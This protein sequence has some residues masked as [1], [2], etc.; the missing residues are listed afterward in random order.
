MDSKLAKYNKAGCGMKRR[1]KGK[2]K[3]TN[4]FKNQKKILDMLEGEPPLLPKQLEDKLGLHHSSVMSTLRDSSLAKIGLIIQ[5]DNGKYTVKWHEPEENKI[6]EA[7]TFFRRKLLRNPSPEEVAG[8]IRKSPAECRDLLFRYITGYREPTEDGITSSSI[9]L[10]R[11]IAKSA[12]IMEK[13]PVN[14][15]QWF[16]KGIEKAVISGINKRTYEEI[17]HNHSNF[18][19]DDARTYFREF[20]E[21]RSKIISLQEGSTIFYSLEFSEAA[22]D[23]LHLI[24]P[25]EQSTEI[26]VPR[27]FENPS[28]GRCENEYEEFEFAKIYADKYVLPQETM[29]RIIKLVGLPHNEIDVLITLKKFCQN[30]IEVDQLYPATKERIVSK[31]LEIA[32]HMHDDLRRDYEKASDAQKE[33]N[34]AFEIIEF[35]DVRNE[36]VIETAMKYLK[37]ILNFPDNPDR[38]NGPDGFK[39]GKWLARD[40]SLKDSIVVHT[41]NLMKNEYSGDLISY[42]YKFL[43]IIGSE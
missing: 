34:E 31:L 20:P 28:F 29:N 12:W 27:K 21:L 18:S 33:I 38:P 25:L 8:Q 36:I 15:K 10:Q 24:Q 37:E 16:E 22:R 14:K 3:D 9:A 5:L 40:P 11:M 1:K 43:E 32:F 42:Y 26:L 30:A 4:D 35:L 41:K 17:V 19:L 13:L 6:K 7:F 2:A 39:V 23:V